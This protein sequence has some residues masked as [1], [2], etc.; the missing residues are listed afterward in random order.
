MVKVPVYFF[1]ELDQ[2]PMNDKGPGGASLVVF[3]VITLPL[4]LYVPGR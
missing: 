2:D 4:V 1:V 3:S